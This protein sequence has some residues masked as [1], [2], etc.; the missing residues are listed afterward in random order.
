M[1][2]SLIVLSIIL[3]RTNNF[4]DARA[5]PVREYLVRLKLNVFKRKKMHIT[6]TTMTLTLYASRVSSIL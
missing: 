4:T 5:L 1:F 3:N 2:F 6:N